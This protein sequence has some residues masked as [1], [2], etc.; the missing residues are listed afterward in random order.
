MPWS[1]ERRDSKW[2][3]V[4]ESDGSSA[5]CHDSRADAI[6]QQRALY[7]NESRMAS[8]YDELDS[9]TL[10]PLEPQEPTLDP[11]T[12]LVAAVMERMSD[13]QAHTDQ[14]LIAALEAI[15]AR[16]PVVNFHAP[17]ITVEPTPVTVEAPHVTVEAPKVQVDGAT[18]YVPAA[19]VT[20]A[21]PAVNVDVIV[22]ER[23][24]TITF[25][26]DPLTQQVTKADVVET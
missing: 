21:P 18:V 16:D 7:A 22:P 15:G 9:M 4:K 5:G 3:V 13:R 14:A 25:E 12:V 10:P 26:R 19:Q 6:K 23:Q 1:L 20:V 11:G 2:C 24:K 8:M 17:P